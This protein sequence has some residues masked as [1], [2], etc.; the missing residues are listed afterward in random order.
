MI[1]FQN[2]IIKFYQNNSQNIMIN[3]FGILLFILFYS[4]STKI[5]VYV[6]LFFVFF[7]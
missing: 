1:L 5:N 3:N 4:K 6:I 2:L 7:M